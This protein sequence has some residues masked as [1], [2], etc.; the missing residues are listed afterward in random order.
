M[1]TEPRPCT[2]MMT[3]G[4]H[5]LLASQT[6]DFTPLFKSHAFSFTPGHLA[7]N[8]LTPGKRENEP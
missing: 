5:H 2:I 8:A 6:Q 7:G 4:G 1:H 3:A